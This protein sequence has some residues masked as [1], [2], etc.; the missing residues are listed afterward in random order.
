MA[1]SVDATG[2]SIF[3][4]QLTAGFSRGWVAEQI[5]ASPEY[6]LDLVDSIYSRYLDRDLDQ[7]GLAGWTNL[8]RDGASDDYLLARILGETVHEEFYDK[9]LS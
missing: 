9:T 7:G 5:F 1:R 2:R 8:K 4:A 6:Q 3:S